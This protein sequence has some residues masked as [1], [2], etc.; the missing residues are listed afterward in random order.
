[1]YYYGARYYDPRAS[2]F[3]GIDPLADKYPMWSSFTYCM[4]NPVRLVDP[5]GKDVEPTDD[6]QVNNRINPNH[7]DYNK[8]FHEQYKKL[9][10]DKNAVYSF[11][12]ISPN[13]GEK[14]SKK[15]GEL[16]CN[17]RNEKGQ[18]LI[19]INYSYA[20]TGLYSKE[21]PLLEETFH[22]SQFMQGSLGF[23]LQDGVYKTFG[24]DLHDEAAAQIFAAQ[25][26]IG[27]KSIM[28]RALLGAY[29]KGG[30]ENAISFMQTRFGKQKYSQ[31]MDIGPISAEQVFKNYNPNYSKPL[32]NNNGQSVVPGVIMRKP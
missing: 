9:E 6:P 10:A 26:S 20:A 27:N 25:N 31:T 21:S 4:N 19:K 7:K 32:Y 15:F 12:R 17:G 5:D 29:N 22:A 30:M 14:G 28:E 18:D 24:T 23:Q 13:S 3:L 8:A 11:N 2:V 16:T 1:V